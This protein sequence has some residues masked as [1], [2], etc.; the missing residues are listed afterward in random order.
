MKVTKD[1]GELKVAMDSE[2]NYWIRVTSKR[3]ALSDT[4]I[5][6]SE[7]YAALIITFAKF[8]LRTCHLFFSY[9]VWKQ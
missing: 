6:V 5:I 1:K 7:E 9:C 3:V 2:Y 8:S 4:A